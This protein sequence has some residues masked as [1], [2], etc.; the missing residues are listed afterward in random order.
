[1]S[2]L[3]PL[4]YADYIRSRIRTVPDWPQAGVQFRDITRCC[5]TENL[6]RAGRCICAPLYGP[7]H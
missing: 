4:N 7:A 3:D 5:K 1:M 2:T 6:S